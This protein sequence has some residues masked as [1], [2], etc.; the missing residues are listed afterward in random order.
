[1]TIA[2][3]LMLLISVALA[4]LLLVGGAGMLQFKRMNNLV[5]VMTDESIPGLIAINNVSEAYRDMRT[6][7]LS[8]MAESDPDLRGGFKGKIEEA[9][10]NGQHAIDNYVALPTPDEDKAKVASL[11]AAFDKYLKA[12]NGTI[13]KAETGST[14]L[15]Q[16]ALYGEVM[17]AAAE[18][19]KQLKASQEAKL[20]AQSSASEKLNKAY[21][22][23]IIVMLIVII[24]GSALL[25]VFSAQ[26]NRSISGPLGSM[27]RTVVSIGNS[28]DFTKRVPVSNTSDEVGQTVE[29]FNKLL[30]TLQTSFGQISQGIRGVSGSAN[31]IDGSAQQ[32][33]RSINTTSESASAMAAVVEQV[34]VMVNHVAERAADTESLAMK[35]GK[36]ADDGAEIIEATVQNIDEIASSVK[37]AA[38]IIEALQQESSKIS[39][40]VTVIK[41]VADQTNLLALNAAIEAARAG[42]QGRGFA[43]VADEV[44]KLAERTSQSTQE[45]S[46]LVG[47]ISTASEQAVSGMKQAVTSVENG[48]VKA[49]E[50]GNAIGEIRSGSRTLVELVSDISHAIREQSAA[51]SSMAGQVERVAEMSETASAEAS[52]TTHAVSEL[53]QLTNQMQD[54]V[55]RFRV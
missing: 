50:A 12:F 26:L 34:T 28:L 20:K 3:R 49:K 42:E 51:S 53:R 32:M 40:M 47:S 5:G 8:F 52:H 7:I 25:L 15:A 48:V 21:S 10:K 17:P 35:S 31:A 41:E 30:D 9:R 18:I 1:M 14:D 38:A 2:K 44:R 55:G 4:G 27:N 45:I 46:K 33:Q 43:V 39:V 22:N 6:L 13:S 37:E 16:A 54:V 36:I 11:K 24:G 29:T 19:E 23:S